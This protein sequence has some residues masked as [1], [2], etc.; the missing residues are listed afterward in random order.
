MHEACRT[1]AM[2][3]LIDGTSFEH[4]FSYHADTHELGAMAERAGVGHLLLTHLI[5]PPSDDSAPLPSP[6][7][8]AP[9]ATPAG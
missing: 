4:V 2:R 5:P 1:A 3:D 6:T 7:T 9:A 8:S